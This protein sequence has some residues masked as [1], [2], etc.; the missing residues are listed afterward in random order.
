MVAAIEAVTAAADSAAPTIDA[1]A[2][3]A[4]SMGGELVMKWS[5]VLLQ[6]GMNWQVKMNP[7]RT[8]YVW[9]NI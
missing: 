8:T 3:V 1:E 5:I 4:D 7:K 6:I 9:T 2:D